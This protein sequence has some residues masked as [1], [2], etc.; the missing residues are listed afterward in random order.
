MVAAAR[1]Q[2]EEA[3]PAAAWAAE[4]V[5]TPEQAIAASLEES[6]AG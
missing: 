2:L 4:E 1:T 5:T 3:E 6:P